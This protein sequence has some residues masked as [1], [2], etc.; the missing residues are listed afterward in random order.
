MAAGVTVPV[1]ELEEIVAL[2]EEC[3]A[4]SFKAT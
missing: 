3:E 2:F 1:W 4:A